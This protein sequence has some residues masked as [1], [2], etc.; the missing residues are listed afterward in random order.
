MNAI[1]AKGQFYEPLWS[2][3]GCSSGNT[4]ELRNTNL[5]DL[6]VVKALVSVL[7]LPY[8]TTGIFLK[9]FRCIC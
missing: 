1:V 7:H 2:I 5:K 3:N 8:D 4:I 9:K 6:V